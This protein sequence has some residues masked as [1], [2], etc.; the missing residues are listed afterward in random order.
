MANQTTTVA[1]VSGS[2][3]KL[4]ETELNLASASGT[5]LL[6]SAGDSSRQLAVAPSL[7][8]RRCAMSCAVHGASEETMN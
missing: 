5:A 7:L 3:R 4:F 1:A 2:A 8:S 6:C